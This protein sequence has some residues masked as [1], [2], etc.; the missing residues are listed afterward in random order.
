MTTILGRSIWLVVSRSD[1]FDALD[2]IS[3]AK[4][5]RIREV[6]GTREF[7]IVGKTRFFGICS[8]DDDA[9]VPGY[10]ELKEYLATV[11]S[12]DNPGRHKITTIQSAIFLTWQIGLL[13]PRQDRKSPNHEQYT[14]DASR[15][16]GCNDRRTRIES[17]SA[18][19]YEVLLSPQ[20]VTATEFIEIVCLPEAM[21]DVESAMALKRKPDND[22]PMYPPPFFR[23]NR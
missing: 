3:K 5:M 9:E 17:M 12:R 21:V 2:V 7:F 16:P 4:A 11:I 23:D 1:E 8:S 10:F 22:N 18:W 6:S 15:R 14:G 20:A 19:H 13:K